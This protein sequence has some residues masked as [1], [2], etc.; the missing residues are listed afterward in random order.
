MKRTLLSALFAVCCLFCVAEDKV[1]CVTQ[2]DGTTVEFT[3]ADEPTITFSG[4]DIVITTESQRIEIDR[5]NIA[6]CGF[7]NI[8]VPTAVND[9]TGADANIAFDFSQPDA[10]TISGRIAGRKVAIYDISGKQ[11]EV[12]TAGADKVS[13]NTSK[14]AQG[15]YI[16]SVEGLNSIKFVK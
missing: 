8:P 5:Y 11:C 1:F 16:L 14:L 12:L 3:L 15:K 2:Q 10:I 13:I 9:V 7:R 6:V 4:D